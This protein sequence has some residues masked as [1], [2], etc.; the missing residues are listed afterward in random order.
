[1]ITFLGRYFTSNS[2]HGDYLFYLSLSIYICIVCLSFCCDEHADA[3]NTG[4]R[5]IVVDDPRRIGIH[6]GRN[7]INPAR[8]ERFQKRTSSTEMGGLSNPRTRI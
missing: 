3:R 5:S 8:I 4:S 1:M 6:T 7:G 2:G